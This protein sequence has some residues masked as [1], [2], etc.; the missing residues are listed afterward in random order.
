MVAC[1]PSDFPFSTRAKSSVDKVVQGTALFSP[2]GFSGPRSCLS[3]PLNV[4]MCMCGLVHVPLT[5]LHSGLRVLDT[6]RMSDFCR[7]L[8]V[9]RDFYH[10]TN[11]L[12]ATVQESRNHPLPSVGWRHPCGEQAEGIPTHHSPQVPKCQT[13]LA[14]AAVPVGAPLWESFPTRLAHRG[15]FLPGNV[16]PILEFY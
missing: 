13:I 6:R 14:Q 10:L 7:L 15:I 11:S 16:A 9:N 3:S 1:S 2:G 12:F 5:P 8:S 4:Y